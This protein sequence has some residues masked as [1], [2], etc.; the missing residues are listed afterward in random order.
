ME[1]VAELGYRQMRSDLHCDGVLAHN[2]ISE[3]IGHRL[4]MRVAGTE[5]CDRSHHARMAA[6]EIG[7][8]WTAHGRANEVQSLLVQIQSAQQLNQLLVEEVRIVLLIR[9]VRKATSEEI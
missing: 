1:K 4:P 6:G 7:R 2:R 9:P 3:F 5:E 8:D